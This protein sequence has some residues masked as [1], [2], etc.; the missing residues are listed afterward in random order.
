MEEIKVRDFEVPGVT[1][2]FYLILL[3]RIND[4]IPL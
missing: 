4:T 3:F 2:L 1:I